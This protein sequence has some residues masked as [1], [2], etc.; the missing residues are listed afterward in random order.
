MTG[1]D[2][3]SDAWPLLEA[4]ISRAASNKPGLLLLSAGPKTL[5]LLPPYTISDAE[6]DQGLEMI[7]ETLEG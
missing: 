2:I 5:R 6:I 4:A 1:I 3:Q 7:R